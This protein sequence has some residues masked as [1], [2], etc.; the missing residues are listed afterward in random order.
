MS[1]QRR[2]GNGLITVNYIWKKKKRKKRETRTTA[3]ERLLTE[4]R[5]F[6]RVKSHEEEDNGKI[7]PSG[8]AGVNVSLKLGAD[9]DYSCQICTSR[10]ECICAPDSGV[11]RIRC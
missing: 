3:A 11:R 10:L 4:F 1:P 7:L 2:Q 6:L 9:P 8:I 5:R